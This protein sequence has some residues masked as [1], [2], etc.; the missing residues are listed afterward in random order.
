[1]A[2]L[3]AVTACEAV[4]QI[5]FVSS[6]AASEA[7]ATSHGDT[8]PDGVSSDTMPSESGSCPNTAPLPTIC[9]GTIPCSGQCTTT[10]CSKCEVECQAG[11]VCCAK[12]G[13]ALQCR[14]LAQG[15]P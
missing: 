3:L 9:C 8:G 2:L 7:D 5:D 12:N 13:Q 6:D 14:S 1:M 4:P 10:N 11:Q 15:C